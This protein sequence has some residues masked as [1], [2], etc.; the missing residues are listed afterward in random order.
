[1]FCIIM[2][3][4]IIIIIIIIVIIILVVMPE[5]KSWNMSA[6]VRLPVRVCFVRVSNL[7]SH[8][9]GRTRVEDVRSWEK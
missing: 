2:I 7:V 5:P 3:I 6:A 8:L 1:M 9:K 4:I